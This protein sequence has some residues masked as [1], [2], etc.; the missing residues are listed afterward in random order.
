MCMAISGRGMQLTCKTIKAGNPNKHPRTNISG[1]KK[2]H[3]FGTLSLARNPNDQIRNVTNVHLHLELLLMSMQITAGFHAATF[4][5][6]LVRASS[7][8]H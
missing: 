5:N 3:G 2:L 7:P 1:T 8:K 4:R 6:A